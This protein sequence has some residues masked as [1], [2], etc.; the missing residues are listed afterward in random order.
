MDEST[1]EF[2]R[3]EID[4]LESREKYK[5]DSFTTWIRH[6]IT[7]LVGLL[8][9]LVAFSRNSF[10]DCITFYIFS[11]ILISIA[12]S[13]V[14]GVIF[15]FHN[16]SDLNQIIK[17]ERKILNKRLKGDFNTHVSGKITTKRIYKICEIVFYC[18][19]ILTIVLLVIYG[20][21]INTYVC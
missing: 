18:F 21:F 3:K 9:V 20:I 19:S 17:F 12:I 13:I 15:L 2:L 10:S 5:S 14:T 7:I 6:I 4:K 16:I 8:T 1:A 11:S